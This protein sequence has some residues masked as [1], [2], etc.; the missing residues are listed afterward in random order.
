[1]SHIGQATSQPPGNGGW[2]RLFNPSGITNTAGAPSFAF[3][4]AKGGSRKC[5]RQLGLITCPQQNQIEHAASPPTLVK[6]ARMGSPQREW[7]MQRSLKVGDPTLFRNYDRRIRI[8]NA[9][10]LPLFR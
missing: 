7:C 3:F 5:R 10:S 2:P 6:N 9:V 4:F 8:G 1:M